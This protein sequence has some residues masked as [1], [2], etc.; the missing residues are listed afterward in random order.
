LKRI[1]HNG[2]SPYIGSSQAGPDVPTGFN[3]V[4]SPIAWW[5]ADAIEGFSD[6][7]PLSAWPDSSVYGYHLVE[8]TNPPVY[9]T[10]VQN[11]LPGVR[12]S[13]PSV[14]H[15]DNI[16]TNYSN[17]HMTIQIVMGTVATSKMSVVSMLE[18]PADA[19][20]YNHVEILF[21]NART[22]DWAPTA[23]FGNGTLTDSD[24][25]TENF[26]GVA[27]FSIVRNGTGVNVLAW[28][29]GVSKAMTNSVDFEYVHAALDSFRVGSR[30]T[31]G[32]SSPFVGDLFEVLV[33]NTALV[34]GDRAQNEAGL[35]SK[36]NI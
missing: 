5:K 34:T 6:N 9:K 3:P 7:D 23:G 15:V 21:D 19:D 27:V 31:A 36:W 30:A 17:E 35:M 32:N 14:M 10:G 25:V 33:Y 28:K 4:G 13:N 29:D 22:P 12:F 24:F 20:V 1:V 16:G 26:S 2:H 18:T 11:M 8:A